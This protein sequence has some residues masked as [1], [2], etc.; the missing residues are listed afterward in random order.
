[1]DID[2]TKHYYAAAILSLI[3][4]AHLKSFLGKNIIKI[5]KGQNAHDYGILDNNILLSALE[6]LEENEFIHLH[7]DDY[8]PDVYETNFDTSIDSYR[9]IIIS[10]N[11]SD[12][13]NK[14][15]IFGD[16]WLSIAIQNIN[17]EYENI[18]SSNDISESG[19][20]VENE[21]GWA[22]IPVDRDSSKL[23][24]AI[25][26]SEAA[27]EEIESNNGYAASEPGE[28]DAVVGTLRSGIEGLK[29]RV[30]TREFVKS[31]LLKPLG[32]LSKK[33]TDSAIGIA[34]KAAIEA[35]IK[36]IP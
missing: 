4:S 1:M 3:S 36:L 19:I 15:N 8:G 6:Y 10:M 23:A 29:S 5:Q 27:L 30:V 17:N 13:Y 33:F 14:H 21:E 2:K 18:E 31:A 25:S 34:A 7:K 22:P 11:D 12:V 28:R 35:L 24:E 9:K 26:A 16:N 20:S 32:Y